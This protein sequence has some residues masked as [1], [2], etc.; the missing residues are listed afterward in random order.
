M[1]E[2]ALAARNKARMLAEL[3][4]CEL[5]KPLMIAEGNR[6]NRTVTLT[7]N[8]IEAPEFAQTTRIDF[9][10]LTITEVVTVR[11]SLQPAD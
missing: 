2:A 1:R 10:H 5:G 4:D 7:A 6:G 11:F 8:R 9:D 3:M